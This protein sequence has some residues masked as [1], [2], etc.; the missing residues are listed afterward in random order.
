MVHLSALVQEKFLFLN[1]FLHS[2]KEVGSITPSSKYLA[3]ALTRSIPWDLVQSVAE[4]GSGTG[5]VTK[6]IKL[7]SKGQTRI[8]LFEKE[9]VLRKQLAL[10]YPQYGCHPDAT[11]IQGALGVEGIGQLDA[12]ISGLPFFNFPEELRIKLMDEIA[13]SLKPGG[14][15]VAFQYSLQMKQLLKHY[16][17]IEQIKVVPLNL[18]PAFVYV[19]RKKELE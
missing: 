8:L 6:Q 5:A 4:L 3:Q 15:F 14:L 16:F 11:D 19:C 18:P 10:Q 2:P 12:I 1:K 13:A 7:A 9:P 17:H